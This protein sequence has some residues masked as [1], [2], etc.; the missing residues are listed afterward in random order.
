MH[1]VFVRAYDRREQ[2]SQ[3]QSVRGW[4]YTI[5]RN[6]I[7]DYYRS[8][9]PSAE[10]PEDLVS[11][12]P[13]NS[14]R[15]GQQLAAC[16]QPLI[17]Q[18]PPKYGEPL[19]LSDFQSVPQAEIARKLGLSLSGAKSRVQRGRALLREA[20]LQCCEIELGTDGLPEDF[21]PRK[22]KGKGGCADCS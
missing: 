4:L 7:V 18:L 13:D 6:A 10:L 3:L 8:K 14:E 15:V 12:D 21:A 11:E 20:L 16:L 1:D 9:K 5:T 19:S 17:N 22:G 2:W